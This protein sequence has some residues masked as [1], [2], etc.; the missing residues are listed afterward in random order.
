MSLQGSGGLGNERRFEITEQTPDLLAPN[1]TVVNN[2]NSVSNF[3][4][5]V[6]YIMAGNDFQTKILPKNP[7][8]E[9]IV[10]LLKK[11]KY[12]EGSIPLRIFGHVILFVH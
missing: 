2:L 3:C 9:L 8:F 7:N 1:C 11:Y 4:C 5:N 10:P 6:K 12:Y